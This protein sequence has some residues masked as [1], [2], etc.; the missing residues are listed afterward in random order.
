MQLLTA[1]VKKERY[2]PHLM[3]IFLQNLGNLHKIE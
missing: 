1:K 3:N 2:L